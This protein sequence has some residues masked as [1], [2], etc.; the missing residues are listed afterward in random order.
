MEINLHG[1]Q[2]GITPKE[3]A[4]F[5]GCSEYTIKDLARRKDI[6]HYRVGNRIMFTRTSLEK[7]VRDQE[8]NNYQMD[9]ETA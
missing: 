7:W 2:M 5:I 1:K 8:K 4:E 9:T 6:P 3:A